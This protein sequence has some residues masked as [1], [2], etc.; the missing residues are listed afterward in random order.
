M[1]SVVLM[2]SVVKN[3]KVRLHGATPTCAKK[4]IVIVLALEV[5]F[6]EKL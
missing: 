5:I 6:L 2:S 1:F 4:A 3:K